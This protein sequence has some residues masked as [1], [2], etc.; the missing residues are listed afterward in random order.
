MEEEREQTGMRGERKGKGT[1]EEG[2]GGQEG[3]EEEWRG[4]NRNRE[5]AGGEENGTC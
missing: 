5:G 4:E 1:G 3:R 2:M